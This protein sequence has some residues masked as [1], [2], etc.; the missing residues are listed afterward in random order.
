MQTYRSDQKVEGAY[1]ATAL[2]YKY[3][4]IGFRFDVSRCVL[5]SIEKYKIA[6]F[7]C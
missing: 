1:I 6:N 3:F 7:G 5:V 2:F 4:Y